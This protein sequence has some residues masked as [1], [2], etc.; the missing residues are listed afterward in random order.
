MLK[1]H[2]STKNLYLEVD[3]NQKAIGMALLQSV[4]SSNE[5]EALT[6]GIDR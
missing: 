1:Y 4:S 3:A 6:N 2:D 5:N